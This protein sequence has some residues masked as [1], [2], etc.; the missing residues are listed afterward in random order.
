MWHA[1]VRIKVQAREGKYSGNLRLEIW[2]CMNSVL[3]FIVTLCHC[4]ICCSDGM[5]RGMDLSAVDFVISYDAPT[6]AKNYVHRTGRTARAGRSGNA[7][8]IVESQEVLVPLY[9]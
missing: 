6:Y 1:T 4:R 3:A 7:V 2:I 9:F 5:A 8:T